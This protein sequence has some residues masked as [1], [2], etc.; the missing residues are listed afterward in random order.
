MLNFSL[1]PFAC[2]PGVDRPDVRE[3]LRSRPRNTRNGR[4][5]NVEIV[6]EFVA[7]LRSLPWTY[8]VD[9]CWIGA[10]NDVHIA[11]FSNDLSRE[12]DVGDTV[13]AGVYLR[14]SESGMLSTLVCQRVF[15]KCCTNGALVE[16]EKSQT[17]EL[18]RS[19]ASS[20]WRT[21]LREVV[22]RC[23]SNEGIDVDAARFRATT[24][25]MLMTPFEILCHLSAE[26]LISGD[27]QSDIQA[28]FD[29]AGDFTMYGLIN[30]VTQSAHRLRASNDWLR[31]VQIER[32]GG[33]ILRGDHNLRTWDFVRV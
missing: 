3:A 4:I 27:E 10:E 14:N 22:T 2:R 24:R 19:P 8:V 28:A 12:I 20:D 32:L 31:A 18:A 16:C 29:A 6:D 30:A 1:L 25:Q 13:Q 9:H 26:G 5:D 11:V 33:E 7:A 21:K 15:R 17:L 23:F